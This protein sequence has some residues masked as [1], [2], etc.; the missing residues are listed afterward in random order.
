[1]NSET[2]INIG[3]CITLGLLCSV[4]VTPIVVL[5]RKLFYVPFMRKRYLDKAIKN[6]HFVT[7]KLVR[8]GEL[9]NNFGEFGFVSGCEVGLYEYE[10]G[11]KKYK[12]KLIASS[13]SEHISETVELYFIKNPKNACFANELGLRG[14]SHWILHYFAVATIISLV[15]FVICGTGDGLSA[16]QSFV[17]NAANKIK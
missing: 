5:L 14:N 7:A 17:D 13:P 3:V 12:T 9:T 8:S 6:K 2:F 16:L 11:G 1:M 4:F 10:Y 15:A